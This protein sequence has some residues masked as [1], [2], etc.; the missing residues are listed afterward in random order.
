MLRALDSNNPVHRYREKPFGILHS[1]QAAP[2]IMHPLL[3][4][5]SLLQDTSEKSSLTVIE[6]LPF[7]PQNILLNPLD[8]RKQ[9]PVQ[10]QDSAPEVHPTRPLP[11][12]ATLCKIDQED[13]PH[14]S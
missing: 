11:Y 7:L 10:K 8:L 4:L 2:V 6:I 5:K 13:G 14:N 3:H 9:Q 1:A 12:L